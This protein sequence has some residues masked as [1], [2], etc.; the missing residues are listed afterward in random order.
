MSDQAER[1]RERV[2]AQELAARAA[3]GEAMAAGGLSRADLAADVELSPGP[4]PGRGRGERAE[5]TEAGGILGPLSRLPV[6]AG[7]GVDLPL[8]LS[9]L[10]EAF[11]RVRV[12]AVP[13]TAPSESSARIFVSRA[14][15]AA[16]MAAYRAMVAST[17]EHPAGS[18]S[19]SAGAGD[20][21]RGLWLQAVQGYPGGVE[22]GQA[23]KE[24]AHAYRGLHVT[25]L[26][27][28][29]S[30]RRGMWPEGVDIAFSTAALRIRAV[31][32]GDTT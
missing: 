15:P 20:V 9:G 23:V 21:W 30:P 12:E 1:L 2:K 13:V 7:A 31:W 3:G 16:V 28:L 18:G 24:V 4:G 11:G 26:G 8:V 29:P 10:A 22:I 5:G 32:G 17:V 25:Y 6:W 19:G 27:T 14:D